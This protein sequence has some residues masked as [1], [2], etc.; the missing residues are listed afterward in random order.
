MCPLP[1][2]RSSKFS[3]I[4]SEVLLTGN[5]GTPTPVY[6]AYAAQIT[7]SANG[8]FAA[9][10]AYLSELVSG[11]E[12]A[13][14]ESVYSRFS[15]VYYTN[16]YASSASSVASEAV[17]SASSV[18]ASV[19]SVISS[20]F[21]PPEA[22]AA[23]DAFTNQL[24]SAVDAASKGIYGTQPSYYEQASSAAADAAS[25]ASD[26]A[27]KAVY[28]TQTGYAEAASLTMA[29]AFATA[30]AAIS[31]AIYGPAPGA[32]E[33]ASSYVADSASQASE[34]AAS[35]AQQVQARVSAAI[36]GPEVTQ[37]AIESFNS[38]MSVALASAQSKISELGADV[39]GTAATAV[40]AVSASVES[41]ASAVSSAAASV[42]DEL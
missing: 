41:A 24:N 8:Q 27:S 33:A 37:G 18:A 36:Y 7:D 15:S 12:P 4:E 40:S 29:D 22:T 3:A 32:A 35:I 31:S 38:R 28:G 21:A 1:A 5:S 34:A 14:T 26:A 39:S 42:R 2:R 20:Y 11:S 13:F 19:S 6:Q 16:A 25:Q 17:A 23:L 30:Q 9:V 10:Q